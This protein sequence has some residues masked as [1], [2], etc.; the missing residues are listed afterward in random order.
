MTDPTPAEAL[1]EARTDIRSA[2]DAD[3]AGDAHRRHQYARSAIDSAA[4][5]LLDPGASDRE[6]V[7]AR[8]LLREGLSLDGQAN[9]CG[10][11]SIDTDREANELSVEDRQ[12]LQTYLGKRRPTA[13]HRHDMSVGR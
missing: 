7:A 12:W 13:E 4:E 10:A 8:Y 11:D 1:D 9:S 2:W 5:T 6:V 3:D